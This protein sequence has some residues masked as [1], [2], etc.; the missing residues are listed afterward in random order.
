MPLAYLYHLGLRYAHVSETTDDPCATIKHLEALVTASVGLLD[1]HIAPL[2]MLLSK[3]HEV[4]EIAEKSAIYDSVFLLAQAKV[5]HVKEFVAW[6]LAREPIALMSDRSG[7][8]A[9]NVKAITDVL[10]DICGECPVGKFAGVTAGLLASRSGLSAKLVDQVLQV[11]FIHNNI[12]NKSI[13]FPPRDLDIDAAFRPMFHLD[14][15]CVMQP[16]PLAARAILNATLQWCR[17]NWKDKHFDDAALGELLEVFCREQM[18]SHGMVVM[19]GHYSEGSGEP[20]Q[21]D[22]V[23]ESEKHIAFFELKSKLMSRAGRS[24]QTISMLKDLS[25]ALVKPLAQAM[26]RQAVLIE[27][28]SITLDDGSGSLVTIEGGGREVLMV[29]VTRGELS[30][31]HD[32]PFI[33]KFLFAGYGYTFSAHD[34]ATKKELKDIG[35]LNKQFAKFR[36]AVMRANGYT[37]GENH[38][39]SSCWSISIFQLMLMLERTRDNVSFFT[40]LVRGR[41]MV[42]PH[43]DF[44]VEYEFLVGLM[45]NKNGFNP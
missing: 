12:P 2:Q 33:G 8:T 15:I 9:G 38:P 45:A 20:S 44:Y 21:C 37:P 36:S 39:F 10:F 23:I 35:E 22:A 14:G 6:L 24:G 28:K 25:Q 13:S 32:R 26:E 31:M 18:Q 34:F 4:I 17:D 16:P 7:I 19:H 30:S 1:V 41:Y 5:A 40:E 3:P 29:S 27:N 42:T 43:R 11:I